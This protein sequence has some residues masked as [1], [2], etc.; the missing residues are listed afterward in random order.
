MALEEKIRKLRQKAL[1]QGKEPVADTYRG[2]T[3]ARIADVLR[4]NR[5]AIYGCPLN[6][7]NKSKRHSNPIIL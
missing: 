5:T 1:A 2:V 7:Y 4:D 3:K 6:A